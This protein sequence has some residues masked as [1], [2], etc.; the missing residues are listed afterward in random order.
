MIDNLLRSLAAVVIG[1]LLILLKDSAMPVMVRVLG[2]AFFLPALVSVVNVYMTRKGASVFPMT[3]IS[4]IDM[5]SMAF[6]IWLMLSPMTFLSLFVI[7]L[8]VVLLAFSLFQMF[9]VLSGRKHSG[10]RWGLMIVPLLLAAVSVYAISSPFET[11]SAASMMLGI[12]AVVSGLSDI[13][14]YFLVRRR[15]LKNAEK[16]AT[17]EVETV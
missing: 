8:A 3:M 1:V 17:T 4:I 15:L 10:V 2:A 14:I 9:V 16:P 6:G 5:G 12:C 11:M 13:F 7:M